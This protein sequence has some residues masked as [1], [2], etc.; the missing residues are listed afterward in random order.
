MLKFPGLVPHYQIELSKVGN[1][2][3]LTLRLEGQPGVQEVAVQQQLGELQ[4]HI[5]SLIGVS[6]DMEPLPEV[7]S[8][9]Q[10]ARPLVVDRR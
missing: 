1:M 7:G 5:K 10:R 3:A 4:N 6:C 9:A 8:P 2:D